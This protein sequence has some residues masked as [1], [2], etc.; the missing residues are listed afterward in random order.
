MQF[1]IDLISI[2]SPFILKYRTFK[3]DLWRA[4]QLYYNEGKKVN[5]Y[6]LIFQV[7]KVSSRQTNRKFIGR[8]VA[9]V[10]CWL[11]FHS[12]TADIVII[13]ATADMFTYK[14]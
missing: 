7:K 1:K 13:H 12:E 3:V 5:V 2:Y 8:I 14:K 10:G 4:T 11:L 6:F 9:L